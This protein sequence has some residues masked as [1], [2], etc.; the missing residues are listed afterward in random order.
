NLV[1]GYEHIGLGNS[2]GDNWALTTGFR[3]ARNWTLEAAVTR[4]NALNDIEVLHRAV[5][6]GWIDS[7]R[8]IDKPGY[9]VVDLFGQWRPFRNERIVAGVAVY[10]LFDK[11]YRAHASVGDYG[12][13]PGW[14]GVA[15][16]MEPGR[17]V[18]LT[19]STS[20]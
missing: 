16:V 2:V 8:H 7:T 14:E 12:A 1:E 18:R 15:G 5:Q 11:H 20:F 9:T 17:N 19:L 3:P 6:V 10:N 13:V 4:F